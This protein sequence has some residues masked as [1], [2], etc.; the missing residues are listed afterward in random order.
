MQ[1]TEN[2]A[3]GQAEPGTNEK[4]NNNYH[5]VAGKSISEFNGTRPEPTGTTTVKAVLRDIKSGKYQKDVEYVRAAKDN[6]AEYSK[7]KEKLPAFTF[8][9]EVKYRGLTP[10]EKAPDAGL[11]N[12]INS[13]GIITADLDHLADIDRRKRMLEQDPHTV[14]VFTSPGNDGL[15]V[16]FCAGGIKAPEDH[17][18]LYFAVERYFKEGYGIKIDPACKDI[19]RLTFVSYD[20]AA[21]INESFD[22]FDV[23]AWQQEPQQKPKQ[24]YI[25]DNWTDASRE[26]YGRKVLENACN[27]I[28]QAQPNQQ[29]ITRIQQARLVGGF[30]A[31]GFLDGSE[32]IPTLEQAVKDSGAEDLKKSN[33]DIAD[34]IENGKLSPLY[35]EN[36]QTYSKSDPDKAKQATEPE[37]PNIIGLNIS[38]FLSLDL[39]VRE[40]IIE[41]ILPQQGL[42]IVY[43]PRGFGK[44]YI[45]LTLAAA[46]ATAGSALRWKAPQARRVLY[47][48]GEMPARTMQER[49][50][51][52]LSNFGE[53]I[54]PDYFKIITPDL[55]PEYTLNLSREA[56]QES[57]DGFV[58]DA[59]LI[60]I[61]SLS[62]LA[63]HGE[64][65]RA[66]SWLPVQ[67]YL[68]KLRRRG[69][70]VIL[71]HHA[72]KNGQ[73]RGTSA[74][75]DILDTVIALK[76][77][78]DYQEEEGA[79]FEV[80]FEKARGICGD[81]VKS[82]EAKLDQDGDR[83]FWTCRDIEDVRLD[84]VKELH[85][86]GMTVREIA[87][88]M[89]ISKSSVH[90]L[91]K[92][93]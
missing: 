51:Q 56:D 87:E 40:Y 28:H 57:I 41:P 11:H 22:F 1:K 18:R 73:Q 59:D 15:K 71:A 79:R 77:P 7:R 64:E 32:A 49:I 17:Y 93:L 85:G 69:K 61:D 90:R 68:L 84:Q 21:Y 70:S 62:T 33:Q 37:K 36:Q 81:D 25:K 89:G 88:E 26:K 29:H 60:I 35:P 9:T 4:S 45:L 44:T 16:G 14:F 58:N 74:K 55:N 92:K 3:G 63:K 82:F 53:E 46:V 27:K 31:S 12:L 72:G 8:G 54:N 83:L 20:P 52:I 86:E 67:E 23:D 47:I 66:K 43:G 30:I 50:A 34:G 6:K 38:D 19:A 10:T 78:K 39:P 2:P 76:R 24:S 91:I 5:N 80:K 65:N 13:T 42:A 75:E 48:D